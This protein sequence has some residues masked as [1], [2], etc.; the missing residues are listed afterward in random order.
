MEIGADFADLESVDSHEVDNGAGCDLS[1]RYWLCG[2]FF[3]GGSIR[4]LLVLAESEHALQSLWL[5]VLLLFLLFLTQC[6]LSS[7][8]CSTLECFGINLSND[9]GA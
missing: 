5:F 7:S 4:L 8:C 1:V 6:L 2:V 9:D 3:F